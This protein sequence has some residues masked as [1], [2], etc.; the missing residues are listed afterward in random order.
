MAVA[1]QLRVPL[2]AAGF[3]VLLAGP[4]CIDIVGADLG[5]YVEREE[6]TF[7][8]SGKADVSVGPFDG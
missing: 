3:V 8:T 7:S 6:K 1:A 2:A 4:G 5:K